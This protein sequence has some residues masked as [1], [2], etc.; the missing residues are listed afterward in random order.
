MQ[1]FQSI[2]SC[3][4]IHPK[5]PKKKER[6]RIFFTSIS[7]NVHSKKNCTKPI[8]CGHEVDSYTL[9]LTTLF[10]SQPQFS[11]PLAYSYK[12]MTKG[13][14]LKQGRRGSSFLSYLADFV[15]WKLHMKNI[16]SIDVSFEQPTIRLKTR[17][18][19][20]IWC[21][22]I[23]KRNDKFIVFFIHHYI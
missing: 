23:D 1:S 22:E 7:H 21:M 13:H 4:F 3:I 12:A 9:W 10:N 2:H 20:G 8:L 19:S 15:G 14:P 17:V 11:H 18:H 5:Q 6:V 16:G